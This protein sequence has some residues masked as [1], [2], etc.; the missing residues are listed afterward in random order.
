MNLF[1]LSE[2]SKI[3]LFF[4]FIKLSKIR[5]FFDSSNKNEYSIVVQIYYKYNTDIKYT[6]LSII[7]YIYNY[8]IKI[9]HQINYLL[10][11]NLIMK[12]VK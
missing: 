5:E 8:I 12:Y 2:N 9:C 3:Y 6:V 7:N 4:S 11:L 10:F 1:F